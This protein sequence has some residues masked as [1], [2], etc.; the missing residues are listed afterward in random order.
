MIGFHAFALAEFDPRAIP[1]AALVL[2]SAKRVKKIDN[3]DYAENAAARSGGNA[4][5][6]YRA[7]GELTFAGPV[8]THHALHLIENLGFIRAND[9]VERLVGALEKHDPRNAGHTVL[10]G[11]V[12]ILV[13]V[14]FADFH[15]AGILVGKLVDERGQH[16]ARP[17]PRGP[18][19]HNYRSTALRDFGRPIIRREFRYVL[20]GHN[21][22]LRG[23]S[24]P[25]HLR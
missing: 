15:L 7:M 24:V 10:R 14:H 19:I 2:I 13:D 18:E 22:A 8:S 5:A 3:S 17:A 1:A 4:C 23:S 12:G 25:P 20:A 9:G 16:S 11:Q 6:A 21:S